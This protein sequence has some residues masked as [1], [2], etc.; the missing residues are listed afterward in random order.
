MFPFFFLCIIGGLLPPFSDF[1]SAALEHYQIHMLHLHPNSVFLLA[2]F[3]YLCKGILGG[4][5]LIGPLP[6]L[7][8]H[9]C[10]EGSTMGCASFRMVDHMSEWFIDMVMLKKVENL[11]ACWI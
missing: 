5:V 1:F 10:K 7:L 2:T 9:E 6:H 11:H 3:A 4:D 8:Q